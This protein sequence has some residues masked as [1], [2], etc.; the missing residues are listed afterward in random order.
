MH[1][2]NPAGLPPDRRRIS[3][4]NRSRPSGV[5]KAEWLDGEMQSCPIGTPRVEA[6]SA[7]DLRGRQSPPW[8]GLAPWLSLNS[9]IFTCGCAAVAAKRSGENCPSGVRAPK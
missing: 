2:L 7:A 6:I 3:A 1:S 4:T 9:T 8:P 5:E